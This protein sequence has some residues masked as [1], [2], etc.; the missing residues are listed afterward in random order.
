MK[1]FIIIVRHINYEEMWATTNNF[2]Q[3][4]KFT[5]EAITENKGKTVK[6]LAV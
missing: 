6:I 4:V 2:K 3:A 1:K 5:L